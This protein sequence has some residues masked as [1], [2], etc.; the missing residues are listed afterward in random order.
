MLPRCFILFLTVVLFNSC[1]F[2]SADAYLQESKAAVEREDY[3]TAIDLLN[4]AI[5]KDSRLKEAY[6]QRGICYENIARKDSAINDYKTL[7]SFDANN[8]SAWYF[9][10]HCKYSQNKF[11]EAVAC[12]NQALHSKGMMNPNGLHKTDSIFDI[13]AS[14]L[15]YQRGLAYYATDQVPKAYSDFQTCIAQ[16]YKPDECAYLSS[17]CRMA[18]N[19]N[20]KAGDSTGINSA[21]AKNIA[22]YCLSHLC[23]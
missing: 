19:K 3:R 1:D 21:N 17:L 12:Y 16:K 22:K 7:L 8:T 5:H 11:A 6:L 14:E 13:P 4:K 23:R 9:T 2:K 18:T 15:Y 20:N 10:G